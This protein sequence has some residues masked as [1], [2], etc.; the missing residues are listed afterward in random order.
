[1]ILCIKDVKV[2]AMQGR[3]G[4]GL[5]VAEVAKLFRLPLTSVSISSFNSSL[6]WSM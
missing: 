2:G 5:E 6:L 3:F 1:V 4:F